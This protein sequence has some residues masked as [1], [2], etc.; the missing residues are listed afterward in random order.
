MLF[1]RISQFALS[2]LVL[3][4]VGQL[5]AQPSPAASPDFFELNVRPVLAA[6]CYSCHT[7]SQLGDLRVDSREALLKGGKRGPALKPGDPD[8]SLLISAIKQTDAD[9]KMPMGSKLKPA[10][11][12]DLVAWVKAGATGP[13]PP[14]PAPATDANGKYVIA[15]EQKQFWSLLPLKTPAPPAVKDP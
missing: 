1:A 9:L 12:D 10:E 11:I 3:G 4:A 14:P 15:P 6:N 13:K 2:T 5:R 8:A 7:N